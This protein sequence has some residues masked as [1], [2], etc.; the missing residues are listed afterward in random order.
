MGDT[1]DYANAIVAHSAGVDYGFW[2]FNHLLWRATGWLLASA[3]QPVTGILW[4][5]EPRATALCSLLAIN[6]LAGLMTILVLRHLAG[7]FGAPEWTAHLVV[8][9]L[10][11]SN[12]FLMFSQTGAP[13]V[14]GLL[15]L[16][17]G[18]TLL[19]RNE[20]NE[21]PRRRPAVWAGVALAGA[22]CLWMPFVLFLPAALLAPFFVAGTGNG[23]RRRVAWAVAV[24]SILITLVYAAVAIHLGIHTVSGLKSWME[25]PAHGAPRAL[26]FS[27]A[28][29]SFARSLVDM[30][31]DGA[32]FKRFL[33]H[34]P[35]NPVSLAD[36][37][38][39]SLWKF[40]LACLFL[41]S[42]W[43]SMLCSQEGRRR[44]TLFI[45]SIV[46]M[47]LVILLIVN[48][49]ENLYLP[50][51]PFLFLGLTATLSHSKS[52]RFL[53]RVA[54]ASLILVGT[55]NLA[56]LAVPVL[57]REKQAEIARIA[58]LRPVLRPGSRVVVP[59]WHDGLLNFA[60]TYPLDPINRDGRLRVYPAVDPDSALV[61]VWRQGVASRALT[62]WSEGG[63]VWV[64][65]RVLASRPQAEWN[66]V[67]G[68]DR[69]VSWSDI[70]HFFSRLQM[71]R[72]VG[73]VDG[74]ALLLPT[75]DNRRN[76][77]Q[78]LRA[79]SLPSTEAPSLGER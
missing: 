59:N 54:V 34:D 36:L 20:S 47:L 17:T 42:L 24:T 65:R 55:A 1:V 41:F 50:V 48:P 21:K 69:R 68:T 12:A 22:V 45:A 27:R 76:L 56:A 79:A 61:P 49:G 25:P 53:H 78:Y 63:D 4:G 6:W 66:W 13:Y 15:L 72:S 18:C 8:F 38:R 3:L 37:V 33:L 73:G 31:Y 40:A 26:S 51:L 74:F 23:R 11:F 71:G 9:G 28:A 39:T 57:E 77:E 44:L 70:H 2:E 75:R 30:S 52:N 19:I 62:V 14:P 7:R 67:E 29:F 46:P 10:L 32:V 43:G 35:F 60:R 58:E 5:M 16:L 64:S